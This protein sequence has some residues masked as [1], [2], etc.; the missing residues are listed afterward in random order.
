[1]LLGLPASRIR[2]S[3]CESLLCFQFQF[4]TNVHPVKQQ[5]M[6]LLPPT[7][8]AKSEFG[9]LDSGWSIH[10]CYSLSGSDLTDENSFYPLFLSL[11]IFLPF[12]YT[13]TYIRF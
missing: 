3:G 9:L 6:A 5:L 11:S 10:S 8:E 7:G 12:K 4:R 2:L 1:M 13:H